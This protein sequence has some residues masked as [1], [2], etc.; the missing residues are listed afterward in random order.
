MRPHYQ[1][2]LRISR[3]RVRSRPSLTF[4]STRYARAAAQ[5]HSSRIYRNKNDPENREALSSRSVACKTA[6]IIRNEIEFES[7][8]Q[9]RILR[10]FLLL[11]LLLISDRLKNDPLHLRRHHL[12]V[13][14]NINFASIS[15]N[16]VEKWIRSWNISSKWKNDNNVGYSHLYITKRK[17]S[18]IHEYSIIYNLFCFLVRY[19]LNS[20]T[21]KFQGEY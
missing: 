8:R 10:C 18:Y 20:S 4:Y 6:W 1:C 19:R 14:D 5:Q 21:I 15:S 12:R 9:S 17:F 2:L 7:R 16:F 11:L 3:L 13:N